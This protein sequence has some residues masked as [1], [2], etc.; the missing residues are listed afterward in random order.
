V[1]LAEIRFGIQNAKDSNDRTVLTHWLNHTVMPMFADRVLE[2]TEDIM[3]EWRL[4]VEEGRKIGHTYSRP[5]LIIAAIAIHHGLTVVTCNGVVMRNGKD[6]VKAR[7]GIQS[8][9]GAANTAAALSAAYASP[10]TRSRIYLLRQRKNLLSDP[11]LTRN[12]VVH[13]SHVNNPRR[14][15]GETYGKP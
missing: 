4:P 8:V 7:T 11:R 6:F 1:T 14:K 9:G 5:D 12:S 2:I 15:R 13:N 10:F 3:L